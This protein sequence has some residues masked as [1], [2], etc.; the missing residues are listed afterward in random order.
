MP[1]HKVPSLLPPYMVIIY[2]P[3][4]LLA[5]DGRV[6]LAISRAV[7]ISTAKVRVSEAYLDADTRLSFWKTGVSV[8]R[9]SDVPRPVFSSHVVLFT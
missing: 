5:G 9:S 4:S 7:S 8:L 1:D 2:L 6:G 3:C